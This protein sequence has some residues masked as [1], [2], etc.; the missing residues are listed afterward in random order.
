MIACK[1]ALPHVP[2]MIGRREPTFRA[3][4]SEFGFLLRENVSVVI[5]TFGLV[6][7]FF[8]AWAWMIGRYSGMPAEE[9]GE[10]IRFSGYDTKFGD[11]M[12]V[13]VR[14]SGG[15]VEAVRTSSASL[16]NC[17]V[18]S[19]IRLVR[20]GAFLMVTPQGCGPSSSRP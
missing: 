5:L 10:V 18:G 7:A 9:A 12:V 11:G 8:V 2:A 16:S 17:Q 14:T 15:A 20:R 13:A 3:T 1:A 19:R 4:I 6:A